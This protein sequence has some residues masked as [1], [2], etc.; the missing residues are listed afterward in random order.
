MS[1]NLAAGIVFKNV[2]GILDNIFNCKEQRG[3]EAKRQKKRLI[4]QVS[5]NG[6]VGKDYICFFK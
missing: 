2:L 3:Q 5:G 6:F 1:E 4:R